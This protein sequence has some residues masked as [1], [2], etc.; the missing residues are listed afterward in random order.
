MV[1]MD[2]SWRGY[3]HVAVCDDH[4]RVNGGIV[5]ADLDFA[6]RLYLKIPPDRVRLWTP[7]APHW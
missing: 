5:H 4:G 6:P 3:L 7:L 1:V 2:S